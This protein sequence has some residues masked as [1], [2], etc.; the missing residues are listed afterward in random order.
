MK[1]ILTGVLVAVILSSVFSVSCFSLTAQDFVDGGRGL[2]GEI[3]TLENSMKENGT[4]GL[5]VPG[6]MNFAAAYKVHTFTEHDIVAAYKEKGSVGAL[7]SDEYRW[8]VPTDAGDLVTVTKSNESGEWEPIGVALGDGRKTA[9]ADAIDKS[10]L[11]RTVARQ[12]DQVTDMKYVVS[13]FYNT[14]FAYVQTDGQ[15]YLVPYCTR[16]EFTGLTNGQMYTAA[17]V[18][19][20]LYEKYGEINPEDGD[21]NG[22]AGADLGD[23]SLISNTPDRPQDVWITLGALIG[24][25][26]IVI[27]A[28]CAVRAK[29]KKK[30]DAS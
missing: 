11:T 30:S 8:M 2:D 10:A 7:I 9:R 14:T 23:I 15:E 17:Q 13:Y 24:I 26:A 5:F 20:T 29:M 25:L 27:G 18:M 12:T 1:K 21:L 22:N 6:T 16:P 4:K 3:A 19:D 28:C